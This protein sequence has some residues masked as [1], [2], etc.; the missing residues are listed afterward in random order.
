MSAA[1]T[2]AALALLGLPAVLAFFSGGFFDEARLRAA[3]AACALL[4]IA[5][6]TSPLPRRR[7]TWLALA[8]LA[9]LAGWTLASGQWAPLAG[10]AIADA[11]RVALYAVALAAATLL[12]GCV[13]RLVEPAL[14][15]GCVVVV[16]Y[17]LSGRLLPGL[18]EL[19]AS[20]SAIGRLEQP[21]TYWNGMG[22]LAALGL[23]LCARL[24]GDAGR[25]RRLRGAAAAGA[26]VLQTGLVLS[27]SRGALA[28]AFVGLVVLLALAPLSGQLRAVAVVLVCGLPA[29]YTAVALDGVRA[30][31]GSA[32]T[33]QWQ[34]A[35]ALAVLVALAA[36]AAVL[37]GRAMPGAQPVR[38]LRPVLAGLA[39]AGLVATA[40]VAAVEEDGPA[41]G[42]TA[43][44]L[45]STG[46]NRYDYWAVAAGAFADQPLRGTGAGGF[47]V[48]WRRERT[49][50]E[51]ARDAH[52]LYV[53]TA[54][55][56]GLVGVL[57][58]AAAFGGVVASA[59]H[60]PAPALAGPAAALAAWALHAGLDWDWEL[61]ALTLVAVLLAGALMAAA[62]PAG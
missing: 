54:A 21:L 27:F 32:G 33:R 51:G 39:V 14:A 38:R 46:S 16:G 29:A 30:L 35:V 60:V 7:G 48:A 8:A 9:A 25:P 10:P 17:G 13:P 6:V 61:P 41:S 2:G 23:I 12:L 15:A 44:R 57:L 31:E 26:V 45:A 47:A 36:V 24:A 58:L 62:E 4:A 56:L 11:Q 49:V 42:A 20:R 19:A 53:E 59:R 34:G 3:L 52:S 22:A 18:I 5:A 55:E 1:R 37:A 43:A 50:A 40:A 28:A